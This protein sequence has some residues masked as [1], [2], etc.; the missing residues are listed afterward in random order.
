[1]SKKTNVD[2]AQNN[3]TKQNIVKQKTAFKTINIMANNLSTF[4]TFKLIH[5][6][7]HSMLSNFGVNSAMLS[8]S[9]RGQ[10]GNPCAA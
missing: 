6:N 3:R 1:M 10:S 9:K 2:T 5:L 4:W 7:S 8:S